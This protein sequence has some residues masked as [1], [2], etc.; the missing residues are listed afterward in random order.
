MRNRDNA[1]KIK[2]KKYL[3]SNNKY[4]IILKLSQIDSNKT[5]ENIDNKTA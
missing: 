1:T 3:T 4:D 5:T 2:I